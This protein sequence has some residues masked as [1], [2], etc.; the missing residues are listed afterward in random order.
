MNQTY[1]LKFAL[2]LFL[3]LVLFKGR[4]EYNGYHLKFSIETIE[5]QIIDGYNYI[6]AAYFDLDSARNS[7]YLVKRFSSP[8]FIHPPHGSVYFFKNRLR[9]DYQQGDDLE[10]YHIYGVLDSSSIPNRRVKSITLISVIN[11]NYLT[12]IFNKLSIK[13]TIWMKFKPKEYKR[14]VGYL[15]DYTVFIHQKTKVTEEADI[16]LQALLANYQA[17]IEEL[18][19]EMKFANGQ[20]RTDLKKQIDDLSNEIDEQL[21]EIISKLNGQKVVILGTCTC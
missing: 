20:E 9:Y 21:A 7:D 2:I 12:S 3:L 8:M 1:S 5:G 14:Y 19:E 11:Q 15:C 10:I 17:K 4:A 18:E 16:E 6:A 13:D